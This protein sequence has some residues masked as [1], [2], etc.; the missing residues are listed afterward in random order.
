M[1]SK[2]FYFRNRT[3]ETI[4]LKGTCETRHIMYKKVRSDRADEEIT[5]ESERIKLNFAF[6]MN[7]INF[8]PSFEDEEKSREEIRRLEHNGAEYKYEY[9]PVKESQYYEV[10]PNRPSDL[11]LTAP[12]IKISIQVPREKKSSQGGFLSAIGGFFTDSDDKWENFRVNDDRT[13]G[14]YELKK[15]GGNYELNRVVQN[16]ITPPPSKEYPLPNTTYSIKTVSD[17]RNSK[18]LAIGEDKRIVRKNTDTSSYWIFDKRLDGGSYE[19][20]YV[21]RESVYK[22]FKLSY[23]GK[24]THWYDRGLLRTVKEERTVGVYDNAPPRKW[25]MKKVPNTDHFK[26]YC[27][28]VGGSK[29]YGFIPINKNGI[30]APM[31]DDAEELKLIPHPQ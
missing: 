19:L 9:G 30:L 14:H 21:K 10:G 6:G 29:N 5:D 4:R 7:Q 22:D 12:T 15:I 27:M 20:R 18:F 17:P 16:P 13:H 8:T 3:N 26:L 11:L 1:E 23:S 31:E 2:Y 28:K 25:I 24:G